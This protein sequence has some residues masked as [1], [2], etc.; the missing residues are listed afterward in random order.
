MNWLLIVIIAHL[1]YAGVFIIDRY[2]LKKGFPHP[3]S[4]AFWSSV[5]GI[6]I[7]VL[8]PFGFTVPDTRQIILSIIAGLVWFLAV[9]SFY[10]A[11]YKG[12]SSRVVPIV[13]GLIPILTLV[14]SFIFLGE[15]LT[16][17][18]LIAFCFLVGGGTFLS[19]LVSRTKNSAT[20]KIYLIKALLPALGAVFAFAVYFVMTKFIFL[21]QNFISGL[22]WIRAGAVLAA[23][24]LLIPSNFRR[25]VFA[26]TKAIEQKTIGLFV[27]NKG[28]VIFAGL[29]QYGAIF[30][31]SVTLV[32]ALQGVQYA[33]LLLL[34]FFLFRRIPALKEQFDRRVLVQKIIAIILIGIGLAILII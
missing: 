22:I 10:T 19:L 6:F 25:I 15:R 5:V 16:L 28:L 7:I 24:L 18:E 33:F 13:G 27:L 8:I 31:G 20:K 23:L 4:Y 1:F 29:F 26:K 32:N 21:H 11:L 2:L 30:L 12:E 14:L 3:L 9:I 17:Q 34:A